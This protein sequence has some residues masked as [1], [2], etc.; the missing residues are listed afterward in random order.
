[1]GTYAME[2]DRINFAPVWT[3]KTA[4]GTAS[5]YRSSVHG[6][7]AVSDSLDTFLDNNQL[8]AANKDLKLFEDDLEWWYS[9]QHWWN[10]GY[11][12]SVKPVGKYPYLG[13]FG[14]V[15]HDSALITTVRVY[16][17]IMLL[18]RSQT[19]FSFCIKSTANIRKR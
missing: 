10:E 9:E 6:S 8:M 4:N 12:L 11:V 7:W 14:V 18:K 17:L 3:K 13:K 16:L 2:R 15:F 19:I 5:L 1:M